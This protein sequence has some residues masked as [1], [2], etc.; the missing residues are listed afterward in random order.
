MGIIL[1]GHDKKIRSVNKF[2]LDMLGMDSESELLGKICHNNICMAQ[3]G[4]C[5]ILDLEKKVDNS[6]GCI[7]NREG[8]EIPIIKSVIPIKIAGEK[9]LLEAFTAITEIKLAED[10]IKQ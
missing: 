9:I 10:R 2:A 5:P 1:I 3:K 4:A 8:T 7:L 6:E